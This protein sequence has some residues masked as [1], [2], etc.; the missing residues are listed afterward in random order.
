MNFKSLATIAAVAF[1]FT[2]CDDT[3]DT[4]GGSLTDDMDN[5]IVSTDTFGVISDSYVPDSVLANNTTGYLGRVKDPE[6]MSYITGNYMTQLHVLEEEAYFVDSTYMLN[7]SVRVTRKINRDTDGSVIVDSTS[8][9]VYYNSF[10][11]DSLTNMKASIYPMDKPME[12]GVNYYTT[13]NPKTAGY[14]NEKAISSRVYTAADF[15]RT[16]GLGDLTGYQHFTRFWL[17]DNYTKDGVTYKNYGDYIAKMYNKEPKNFKNSYKFNHYVSPGLYF[18]HTA[19]T[20]NMLYIYNARLTM[21]YDTTVKYDTI[22]GVKQ[23]NSST[24]KYVSYDF[25][26]GTSEVLQHTSIANNKELM[27]QMAADQSCTYIKTPAGLFTTVTLP[28]EEIMRNHEN[29]SISSAKMVIRRIN[30]QTSEKYELPIPTTLMIIPVDSMKSFFEN[31]DIINYRTSYYT[32]YT[33]TS[34]STVSNAYNFNNISGIVTSMWKA[35]QNGTNSENWNKAIIVPITIS[36]TTN[37]STTTISKVTNDMSLG[38]TKLV[39]GTSFDKNESPITISVIYSRF[40][41]E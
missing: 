15:N 20:G 1:A 24:V 6:T 13:F 34:T 3:T 10:Y 25:L 18:E 36:T 12:E 40:D 17:N 16:N 27:T 8:V 31:R 7:D 38:S 23:G 19:G 4:I 22:S 33:S 11:G 28:I 39:R 32:T 9:L 41:K 37:S 35:K 5:I 26:D 21:F 14:V 29:D 2:A 30:N